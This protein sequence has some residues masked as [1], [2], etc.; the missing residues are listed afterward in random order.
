MRVRDA[1]T[2]LL[3]EVDAVTVTAVWAETA[4]VVTVNVA[5]EAPAATVTDA[6]TTTPAFDED[7]ETS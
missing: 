4:E 3:V 5:L 7:R 1:V 2:A 6:G